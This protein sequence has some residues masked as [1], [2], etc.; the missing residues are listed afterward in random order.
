MSFPVLIQQQN[1]D[2]VAMLLGAPSVRVTSPTR[3]LA[4]AEMQGVL[5]ERI[6]EGEIVLLDLPSQGIMALAGKY[7]DDP[8]LQEICDEIYQE[9]DGEPKE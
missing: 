4:I 9:R 5:Q 3:A 7:R 6:V 2:F 1:G 8:T